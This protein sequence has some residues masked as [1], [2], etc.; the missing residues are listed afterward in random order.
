[1]RV[2]LTAQPGWGHLGPVAA[3]A[4]LLLSSGHSVRVATSAAVQAQLHALSIPTVAI[5]PKWTLG[6]SSPQAVALRRG[7][8]SSQVRLLGRLA[9]ESA[10][11]LLDAATA[12]RPD[13]VVRDAYDL[14]GLVVARRLGIPLAVHG[15][16][17]RLPRTL[18]QGAV[19]PTLTALRRAHGLA[20]D[21]HLDDLG[22][23][24]WL[25][26]FPPSLQPPG[27]PP[28]RQERHL[29][30]AALDST[31]D[32]RLPGW[33]DDLPRP[34]VLVTLGTVFNQHPDCSRAS[35]APS[36]TWGPGPSS[37]SGGATTLRR[38]AR[39]P[40]GASRPVPAPEPA[41]RRCPRRRDARGL[42]DGDGGAGGGSAGR[43]RAAGERPPLQRGAGGVAGLRHA[44]HHLVVAGVGS[45]GP[46]GGRLRRGP[47]R[48]PVEPLLRDEAV[49]RAARAVQVE[50]AS[51]PPSGDAVGMLSALT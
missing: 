6:G 32:E 41:A 23:D 38:S 50:V 1:M 14:A 40:L 10:P 35:P 24:L 20:P 8:P 16:T 48:R 13:V 49:L 36:R 9:F 43:L 12:W 19:E 42:R 51:L 4:R 37:R 31:G 30:P 29:R 26:F 2:L 18:V 34:L 39:S 5:G 22:G 33:W 17:A 25:S 44:V 45:P 28:L 46:P 15:I 21:V 27:C 7:R 3:L 11:Q 47:A